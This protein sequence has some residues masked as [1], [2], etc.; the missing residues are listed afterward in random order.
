MSVILVDNIDG[1]SDD[2]TIKLLE[3]FPN[4]FKDFITIEDKES[5]AEVFKLY[6]VYGRLI[7]EQQSNAQRYTWDLMDLPKGVYILSF[8][9]KDGVGR[10][11]VVVKQ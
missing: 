7:K 1:I 2:Y 10:N 5:S 11:R 3:V 4:P 9:G 6:D 8:Q